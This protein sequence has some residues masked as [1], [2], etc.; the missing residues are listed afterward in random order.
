[1]PIPWSYHAGELAAEGVRLADLADRHGT[2]LFVYHR[3]SIAS[4]VAGVREA[5][6]DHPTRLCYSVKANS[7]LRLLKW[8]AG[9][10]VG[11]DVVSEGE[12][13][14]LAEVGVPF[15]R[16]V[17]AGVG[18]TARELERAVAA[19]LWMVNVESIEEAEQLAGLAAER[20][21]RAPISLR[22][23]PDV[24]ARTH[25]HIT[26]GRKVDKFGIGLAEFPPLLEWIP[27]SPSLDLVGLHMHLG[28][29]ITDAEPYAAGLDVLLDCGRAARSAGASLRWINAG[30]GFGISY[31]GDPVPGADAYARAIVPRIR[32]FGAELLLELGRYLVGPAGCLL[33]RV[34]YRKERD[35]R[36]LAVVDAGMTDL[37]RPAL[38]E[39]RHR[40][41]PV[42]RRNGERPTDVGGP[43]C[44]SSDFLGRDRPLPPLESGDLLAILDAGAYGMAMS[45]HYN[46]HPRA[47]EVWIT[48]D[49]SV[50]TIRRRETARDLMAVERESL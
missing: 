15:D 27:R 35:G 22:L 39:A 33:T 11:F 49:G 7:N 17:F 13:D 9:L 43:I 8:L 6:R 1:V 3:P 40:I 18:K 50:E 14:R 26:T 31:D 5:F 20:R 4:R 32:E 38:Y 2:P 44:E 47:A 29:Q 30:G 46:S 42:R 10:E 21:I 48:E 45:S 12:L 25:R 16:V 41:W 34:L 24:D 37:M 36:P 19:G 23:N 28:S